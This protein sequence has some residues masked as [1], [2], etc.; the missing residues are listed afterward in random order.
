MTNRVV[1]M[2]NKL[3][4]T[5][6]YLAEAN[7]H[8]EQLER[9]LR[10]ARSVD[11]SSLRL[12]PSHALRQCVDPCPLPDL[13]NQRGRVCLEGLFHG[14]EPL[15]EHHPGHNQGDE[16]RAEGEDVAEVDGQIDLGAGHAAPPIAGAERRG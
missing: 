16:D 14:L 12:K 3:S 11:R 5:E 7:Q 6:Q 10:R 8:V 2:E 1:A 15:I 13:L 9:E 4:Q